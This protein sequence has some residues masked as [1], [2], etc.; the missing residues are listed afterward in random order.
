MFLL[1]YIHPNECTS[2]TMDCISEF[3]GV[4]A[5]DLSCIGQEEWDFFLL[6]VCEA[7]ANNH[8]AH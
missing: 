4:Q 8:R 3:E 7:H 2:F 1:L 5:V 6:W